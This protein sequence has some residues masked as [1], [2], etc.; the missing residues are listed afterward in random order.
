MNL[1]NMLSA[2]TSIYF[3][4]SYFSIQLIGTFLYSLDFQ[5]QNSGKS[6]Y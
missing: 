2:E 4:Q 5:I 3:F 1:F 6:H